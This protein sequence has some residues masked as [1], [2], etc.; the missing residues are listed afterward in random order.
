MRRCTKLLPLCALIL[1]TAGCFAYLPEDPPGVRISGTVTLTGRPCP[2]GAP[3]GAAV[4]R[5]T[6]VVVE[7]VEGRVVATSE[8]GPGSST[9][10]PDAPDCVFPFTVDRV[11]D[12]PRYT[13]RIGTNSRLVEQ[14]PRDQVRVPVRFA[15]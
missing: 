6:P 12:S 13:I 11:P 5:G 15:A 2:A 4:S 8:L 14:I 1:L 10:R 9:S 3:A 7:N